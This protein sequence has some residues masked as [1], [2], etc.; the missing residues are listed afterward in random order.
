MVFWPAAFLWMYGTGDIK[1]MG[2]NIGLAA[3]SGLVAYGL[4]FGL[5]SFF[6][7][8]ELRQGMYGPVIVPSFSKLFWFVKEP[9]ANMFNAWNLGPAPHALRWG[10][11]WLLLGVTTLK[12]K[13]TIGWSFQKAVVIATAMPVLLLLSFLPNLCVRDPVPFYR[14]CLALTLMVWGPVLILLGRLPFA[15]VILI[16]LVVYGGLRGQAL[17][18]EKRVLPSIGETVYA[19]AVFSALDTG[20]YDGLQIVRRDGKK[21]AQ[22]LYDEWGKLTFDYYHNGFP[23]AAFVANKAGNH[24]VLPYISSQVAGGQVDYCVVQGNSDKLP[25]GQK[26]F[27]ETGG[28]GYMRLFLPLVN[29]QAM[30]YYFY[31][32]SLYF[33]FRIG[34]P[35]RLGQ[36]ILLDLNDL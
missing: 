29:T 14:C 4:L 2:K 36:N 33:I 21:A 11:I 22:A 17:I 32:G 25:N 23:F 3:G 28:R 20:R 35:Q 1:T 8:I 6:I 9:L 16:G 34:P 30:T 5:S 24:H 18:M 7:N 15:S 10:M 31:Q 26:T 19:R 27:A 13:K 12:M